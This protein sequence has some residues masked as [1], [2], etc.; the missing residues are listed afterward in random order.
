MAT[1]RRCERVDRARPRTLSGSTL[2]AFAPTHAAGSMKFS[3]DGKRLAVAYDDGTIEIREVLV[4][5]AK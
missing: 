5:M 1:Q 4:K 3:P 2:L